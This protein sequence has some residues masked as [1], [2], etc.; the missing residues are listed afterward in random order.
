MSIQRYKLIDGE[1]IPDDN[2]DICWAD[3]VTEIE[4]RHGAVIDSHVY[5]S[6]EEFIELATFAMTN[7]CIEQDADTDI[8]N[9]ALDQIA[10]KCLGFDNWIQAYHIYCSS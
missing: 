8:V 1:M 2:G 3:D 5:F 4:K 10:I 9:S 6:P 7:D